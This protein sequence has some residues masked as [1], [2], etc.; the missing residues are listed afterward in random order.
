MV[1]ASGVGGAGK[2]GKVDEGGAA[3]VVG[4]RF[5]GELESMAKEAGEEL[6]ISIKLFLHNCKRDRGAMCGTG[7]VRKVS[8]CFFVLGLLFC[9]E[10]SQCDDISVDLLLGDS[11]SV[12]IRIARHGL[13]CVGMLLKR[14]GVNWGARRK[15]EKC[16]A[17]EVANWISEEVTQN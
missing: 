6:V 9:E 12:P 15:G 13:E 7:E 17:K 4:D 5:E 2:A 3:D 14:R 1:V 11:D 8:G 10:A 16:G